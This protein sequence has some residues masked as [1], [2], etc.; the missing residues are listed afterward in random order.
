MT[1]RQQKALSALIRAPTRAAAAKEAGVGVSTLRRWLKE[2]AEFKT[3]YREAVAEI[4]EGTT[5]KA[6]RAAGEAVEV[7][8]N[9]ATDTSEQAAPRV[10]AADKILIHAAKLTEQLDVLDRLTALEKTMMEGEG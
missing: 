2:D 5:R 10:S 3:A 6:Q 1:A 9:I 8:R 7:L 4:L